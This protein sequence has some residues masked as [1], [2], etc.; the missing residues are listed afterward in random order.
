MPRDEKHPHSADGL[1]PYLTAFGERSS[2]V[3]SALERL[4]EAEN[5]ITQELLRRLAD[6]DLSFVCERCGAMVWLEVAEYDRLILVEADGTPH[7]HRCRPA[8]ELF[9][10]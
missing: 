3:F 6:S 4:R 1:E 9:N 7:E 10:L 2:G 5:G 8:D